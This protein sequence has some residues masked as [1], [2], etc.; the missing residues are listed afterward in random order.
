[1]GRKSAEA[2]P[3]SITGHQQGTLKQLESLRAFVAGM[4]FTET[5]LT[6]CL[7][8][9][10][11]NVNTAAA[12]LMTGEYKKQKGS[13]KAFLRMTSSPGRKKAASSTTPKGSIKQAFLQSTMKRKNPPDAAQSKPTKRKSPSSVAGVAMIDL[14]VDENE[15]T[16]T[17]PSSTP[18]TKLASK[19]DASIET[20]A[21]STMLTSAEGWL[22]CQRWISDA[23][24]TSR[25]GAMNY[26]ECFQLEASGPT[27]LR[28]R[29]RALQARFPEHIGRLMNPLLRENLVSLEAQSLMQESKLPTGASIPISLRVCLP[30]PRK[31]FQVFRSAGTETANILFWEKSQDQTKS[32]RKAP[33]S[34]EQAA[35]DLLQW[36]HYGDV[37]DFQAQAAAST[38]ASSSSDKE[39]KVEELD[40]NDFETASV[41]ESNQMAKEWSESL[42]S[43]ERTAQ[44][45]E[46]EE[47]TGFKNVQLRP[48]QKQALQ[49]MRQREVGELTRGEVE[50]QLALLAEMSSATKK[51]AT[52]ST[53]TT[54]SKGIDIECE[55]GPVLASEKAQMRA[56]TCDGQVDPV[57]HPLWQRRFMTDAKR[58]KLICFFVNEF[59]GIASHLPPAPPKPCSGGILA[60]A[61]GLGVSVVFG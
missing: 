54:G 5:E 28:L 50:E 24:C 15:E 9:C 18:M 3:A 22:L 43:A 42:T 52:A 34:L 41:D 57:S 11:F 58:E 56:Q 13:K 26:Q 40:E 29:G 20:P 60:D 10:G 47:P 16:E 27:S 25:N 37:P 55:C 4:G 1:M 6:D 7:R 23:I 31:F 53:T 48:Y 44:L 33:P 38:T 46:C 8:Q 36:A 39:E 32:S 30:D 19:S 59:M 45:P 51:P 61:M 21:A 12:M 35:F 49:W 2:R 14:S 17:K